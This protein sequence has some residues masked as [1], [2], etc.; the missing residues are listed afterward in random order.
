MPSQFEK[1]VAGVRSGETPRQQVVDAVEPMQQVIRSYGVSEE[2]LSEEELLSLYSR[3]AGAKELQRHL[4]WAAILCPAEMVDLLKQADVA[5]D[6]SPPSDLQERL[7]LLVG[8]KLDKL[9]ESLP[10]AGI[11]FASIDVS[12]GQ[13][14]RALLHLLRLMKEKSELT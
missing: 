13:T 14:K 4:E 12:V 2:R 8:E 11:E 6:R 5:F 3:D 7:H 1:L 10:A 9:L